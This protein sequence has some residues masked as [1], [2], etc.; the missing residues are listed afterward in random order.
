MKLERRRVALTI[1]RAVIV[2]VG[3]GL[4]GPLCGLVW[5]ITGSDAAWIEKAM[6]WVYPFWWVLFYMEGSTSIAFDLLVLAIALSA[7]ILLFI[8][9]VSLLRWLYIK[10]SQRV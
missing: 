1:R 4:F 5:G 9:L 3:A 2:G 7:N 6:Y 10:I 8:V